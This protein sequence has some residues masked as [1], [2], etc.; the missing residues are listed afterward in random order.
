M[1]ITLLLLDELVFVLRDL[2]GETLGSES[3]TALSIRSS[4][5]FWRLARARSYFALIFS[6]ALS[7]LE[8]L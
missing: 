4:S 2:T 6:M 3:S 8:A 7:I 1:I 5:I